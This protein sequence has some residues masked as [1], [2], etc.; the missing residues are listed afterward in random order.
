M[1]RLDRSL[2]V[3]EEESDPSARLFGRKVSLE[4]S[5]RRVLQDALLEG[6]RRRRQRQRRV[7]P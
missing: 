6:R 4:M 3:L 5:E 7:G 1:A 2:L